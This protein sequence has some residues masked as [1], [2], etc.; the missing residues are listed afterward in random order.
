MICYCN[1][2]MLP[3]M[4]NLGRRLKVDDMDDC[5]LDDPL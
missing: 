5:N 2:K 4:Y 3:R 1:A